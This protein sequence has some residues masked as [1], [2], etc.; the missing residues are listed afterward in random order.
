MGD[1]DINEVFNESKSLIEEKARKGEPIHCIWYCFKS[2]CLLF[3]DIEKK[4][5]TLLM[6]QYIDNNLPTIIVIAQNY[7]EETTKIMTDII[8]KEFQFLERE[9]IIMPVIAKNK[10]FG[11]KN[12]QIILEKNGIEELIKVSFKNR[13]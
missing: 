12:N 3:E 8:K 11:N 10:A 4:T 9:I 7:D 5:L 6:N 2:R 1:Q 13:K